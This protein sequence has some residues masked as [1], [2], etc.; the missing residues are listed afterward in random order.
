MFEYIDQKKEMFRVQLAQNTISKQIVNLDQKQA[1]RKKALHQSHV[2][3]ETDKREV[4]EFVQ[5]Q[6]ISKQSKE[7]REKEL[8]KERQKLDEEI[9]QNEMQMQ[10][11]RTEIE[12]DKETLQILRDYREFVLKLTPTDERREII[13]EQQEKLR[14]VKRSWIEKVKVSDFMDNIIFDEGEILGDDY[15]VLHNILT[16]SA[17]THTLSTTEASHMLA[18]NERL[19]PLQTKKGAINVSSLPNSKCFS[20]KAGNRTVKVQERM[21]NNE[22]RRQ[23]SHEVWEEIFDF[24]QNK[25][26]IFDFP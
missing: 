5:Q 24:L 18:P 13:A 1:Q 8:V 25:Y 22:R 10:S 16:K 7:E 17:K 2:D 23:I 3:L 26:L 12:K 15:K 20:Q 21:S 9:R 4:I 6:N 19:P 14:R 11:M